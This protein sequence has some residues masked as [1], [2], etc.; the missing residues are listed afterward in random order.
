MMYWTRIAT[1]PS[2]SG[3]FTPL[4]WMVMKRLFL[5]VPLL[6][7]L[8]AS[9][10]AFGQRVSFQD[11]VESIEGRIEPA[12]ARPGQTVTF[13]LIVKLNPPFYTHPTVQPDPRVETS[14][15][16]IEL[17][18]TGDLLFVEPVTDPPNAKSKMN[19]IGTLTYYQDGAVWEFK[20]VVSPLAAPGDLKIALKKFRPLICKADKND[21]FCLSPRNVPVEA[22]LKV[23]GERVEV[24]EKYRGKVEAEIANRAKPPVPLPPAKPNNLIPVGP[25]EENTTGNPSKPIKLS[26][27][28]D[29]EQQL[30]SVLDQPVPPEVT[31]GGSQGTGFGR[32]LLT[33]ALWGIITLLTPCVFPMVPI[34]VSVFLKQSEK[35]GTNP[36]LQAA[37]YALTIVVVLGVSAMMLLEVF[38]SLS[39]NPWMN[40]GL[41][42]LFVVFA[43]SLFGMYDITVPNSLVN[44]TSNRE[45][46][47]YVGTVFMGLTFSL[48]SFTCVA[49]FLGGFA[50]L[51]ASGN[52]SRLQLALGALTFAVSFAAP[53]FLLALFPS[54]MK[55][56]P[57][58]GGWMNTVKVVMGFLEFA[59]ALKFFRT[60]ELRW[61]DQPAIFSYDIVL[62]LWVAI[63]VALGLYLLGVYR[64]PHDHGKLE[65][66]SPPRM[67]FGMFSLAMAVYL[68]PAMFSTGESRNRPGGIVYSWVDA[69]LLPELGEQLEGS[70]DL[71]RS[72]IAA[73]EN[74]EL[75]FVDFTGVTCTNCRLNEKSVFPKP[76][77]RNLLKRYRV[78]QLYTDTVPESIYESAPDL[79]KR[80]DDAGAN[81]RFQRDYFRDERLP[82]YAILKPEPGGKAKVVAVYFESKIN[83]EAAFIEFLK[84]GLK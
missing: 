59:A 83:D 44:F 46:G 48:I 28:P 27:S 16:S 13:K 34:T 23:A 58:S 33:A 84:N 26:A 9:T 77:V 3:S 47:G 36:V 68:T 41:G 54:L 5:V 43:F 18:I 53:F 1:R 72:L 62:G 70:G 66:L 31:V 19:S 11:A 80:E 25:V 82:L 55:K 61:L 40:V 71:R 30:M 60:A 8:G 2:G 56:L 52:Y 76:E 75:V 65:H 15:T 67:L 22:T 4:P 35:Q 10:E 12:E 64:L 29:Y 39:V 51:S 79:D 21:E 6:L 24:E 32:F 73:Q 45:G 49:P 17:P 74:K 69:F 63:L 14:K 50:G 57:K 42:L 37:V 81:L 78:V 38:R 20:A 7:W